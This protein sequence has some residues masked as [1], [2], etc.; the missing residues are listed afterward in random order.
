M[1][2]LVSYLHGTVSPLLS[3][4]SPLFAK[5]RRLAPCLCICL[6]PSERLPP[7][8]NPRSDTAFSA[9]FQILHVRSCVEKHLGASLNVSCCIWTCHTATATTARCESCHLCCWQA[10]RRLCGSVCVVLGQPQRKEEGLQGPTKVRSQGLTKWFLQ[11]AVE[12]L[13]INTPL[14]VVSTGDNTTRAGSQI[15]QS[16]FQ[17]LEVF[18]LNAGHWETRRPVPHLFHT[19]PRLHAAGEA[20]REQWST[21]LC[22][23]P[24]AHLGPAS[25]LLPLPT[26]SSATFA[27]F[28]FVC[29][30]GCLWGLGHP[31]RHHLACSKVCSVECLLLKNVPQKWPPRLMAGNTACSTSLLGAP[32]S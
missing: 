24:P 1:S 4:S 14:P 10:T 18:L 21:C 7:P 2:S 20:G 8:P 6:K 22:S 17:S 9:L 12:M 31:R 15:K 3:G 5:E 16:L 19:C 28:I 32:K 30:Y 13:L 23:A 29:P 11:K 27:H 25:R 26:T